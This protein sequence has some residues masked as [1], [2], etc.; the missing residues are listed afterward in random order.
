MPFD[1]GG[2][3]ET[4]RRR[5]GEEVAGRWIAPLRMLSV[6]DASL[7]LEAPNPY[8]QQWVVSH[9]QEAIREAAGGRAVHIQVAS[10][11][12]PREPR[13][14]S[15]EGQARRGEGHRVDSR[16]RAED[17][18]DGLNRKFTFEHFVVGPSNRFAHAASMAVA[19]SPAKAYNPLFIYGGVGL[20]KTHLMQAIGWTMIGSGRANR[21]TYVSSEQFTNELITAI[22]TKTT[23]RF[24]ERYRHVGALL[25]D[26]I[27]FIAG[28]EATQEEFFHTFN[29]LY[30]A[31]KQIVLSSDRPPKD[32]DGL[33]ERLVSRFE[34]G[35]VTDI[36]PPDLETRSA[37]LRQKAKEAQVEVPDDLTLFIASQVT[38]NI[39]ELEGALIRVVAYARFFAKPLA[40]E[41]ARE[42]LKDMVREVRARV[43]VDFIQQQVSGYFRISPEELSSARRQRSILYPRQV[44]MFLCRSLTDASLPEIGRAF[45]GRDHTTV[46]HAVEKIGQELAQDSHKKRVVDH[47]TQ[48]ITT[49]PDSTS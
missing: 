45:G 30:D 1:W 15:T 37:I 39:R 23:A 5:V 22:Q 46:L 44:A 10:S 47:L 2:A 31:H 27:Q 8:F 29:A 4:L 32:I 40:V 41:V 48:L 20:G 43:T 21:V 14:A 33:E 36:Q 25:I 26:D 16:L 34:W 6:S 38:A 12:E 24:R 19:E 17:R 18:D 9:Y 11:D 42:V 7:V 28:K 35:L 3:V 13:P 49:S